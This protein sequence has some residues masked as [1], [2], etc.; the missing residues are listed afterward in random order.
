MNKAVSSINVPGFL[1]SRFS[2]K[3]PHRKKV[4]RINIGG[5]RWPDWLQVSTLVALWNSVRRDFVTRGFKKQIQGRRYLGV[6]WLH[7]AEIIVCA[8]GF[9][10]GMKLLRR[11]AK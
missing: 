6:A 1:T 4:A 7:R 9:E 8:W 11:M 5:V 10:C 3:K 2:S